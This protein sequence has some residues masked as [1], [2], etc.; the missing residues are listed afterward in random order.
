MDLRGRKALVTGAGKGIGRAI[1]VALAK[2][3]V[4][5]GLVA[6]TRSD[7][8]AVAGELAATRGVRTSI[9]TADVANRGEIEAAVAS[10]QMELDTID[11]AVPRFTESPAA[12]VRKHDVRV[13]ALLPSTVNAELAASIGLTIG[14]EDRLMQPGDVA[15][16]TVDALKLPQRAFVRDMAILTTNPQ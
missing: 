7:I 3:G 16:L 5:V 2:E 9:A 8:E 6:P 4:H 15:Q 13:T 11:G 10:I 12:E 1:A 14:T